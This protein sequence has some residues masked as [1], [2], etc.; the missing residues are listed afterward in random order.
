M[1]VSRGSLATHTHLRALALSPL[2]SCE[3]SKAARERR[4]KGASEPVCV[5][6]YL[7]RPGKH[8]AYHFS[9]I[10]AKKKTLARNKNKKMARKQR[11]GKR[12]RARRTKRSRPLAVLVVSL[13]VCASLAFSLRWYWC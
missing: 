4:S 11:E 2:W 6:S 7:E 5:S 10:S 12:D 3:A 9:R 8:S 13:C 1:G